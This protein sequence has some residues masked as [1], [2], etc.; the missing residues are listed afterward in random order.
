MSNKPNSLRKILECPKCKT[1]MDIKGNFIYG[2]D[3]YFECPNC[4]Y[5]QRSVIYF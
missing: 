5:K 3:Q 1:E 2:E 4:G